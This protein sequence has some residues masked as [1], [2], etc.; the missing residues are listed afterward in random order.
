MVTDDG[1]G[2]SW[3][4]GFPVDKSMRWPEPFVVETHIPWMLLFV[5]DAVAM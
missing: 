4:W 3:G 5:D 2:S 1:V